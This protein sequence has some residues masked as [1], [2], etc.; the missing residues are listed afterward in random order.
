MTLA[1]AFFQSVAFAS[2]K[3]L[4]DDLVSFDFPRDRCCDNRAF[5]SG[6]TD[7]RAIFDVADHEHAIEF[8]RFGVFGKVFA[9]Y[10]EQQAFFNFVLMRTVAYDC[11]HYR[12]S[13]ES[14]DYY[15]QALSMIQNQPPI[16]RRAEPSSVFNIASHVKMFVYKMSPKCSK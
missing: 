16:Y 4:Y 14:P 11:I 9:L 7:L 13:V 8:D 6:L 2:S 1:V 5:D 3:L 12:N 15:A 10:L